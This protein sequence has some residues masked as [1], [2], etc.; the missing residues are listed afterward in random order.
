MPTEAPEQQKSLA[1]AEIRCCAEN[2]FPLLEENY[3]TV[4]EYLRIILPLRVNETV[5]ESEFDRILAAAQRASEP[6]LPWL[7]RMA[8]AAEILEIPF[9]PR[10]YYRQ[11][12][13]FFIGR[14]RLVGDNVMARFALKLITAQKEDIQNILRDL[15][16]QSI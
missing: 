6:C 3:R 10:T 4:E 9:T 2:L 1:E 13:P 14:E 8:Q 5:T 11:T 15:D 12:E 7:A 16:T